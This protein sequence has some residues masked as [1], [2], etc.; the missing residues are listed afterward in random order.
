MKTK[1]LLLLVTSDQ[2]CPTFATSYHPAPNPNLW[3]PFH[4]FSLRPSPERLVF[5]AMLAGAGV[6]PQFA[7]CTVL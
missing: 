1:F 7:S 5:L 3:I 6:A 4:S 2:A